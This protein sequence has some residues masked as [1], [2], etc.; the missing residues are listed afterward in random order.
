MGDNKN[1]RRGDVVFSRRSDRDVPAGARGVVVDVYDDCMVVAFRW[2]S[3][4]LR[5]V[6]ASQVEGE[7]FEEV[8]FDDVSHT[9]QGLPR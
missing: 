2:G 9:F 5:T 4:R 8:G 1:Y 3:P 6:T 7:V